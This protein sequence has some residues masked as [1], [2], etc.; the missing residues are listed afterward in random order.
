LI[1]EKGSF[2]QVNNKL[3]LP[4]SSSFSI[5]IPPTSTALSSFLNIK[6]TIDLDN[7]K[8]DPFDRLL[9]RRD[10]ILIQKDANS[11]I[12]TVLNQLNAQ[13][14]GGDTIIH[15]NNLYLLLSNRR[16]QTYA[17]YIRDYD[18]V[19]IGKTGLEVLL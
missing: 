6:K 3:N 2:Q 16:L 10:N 9:K 1:L 8:E 18:Y 11:V 14:W 12:Y 19:F 5:F 4:S 13:R 7:N 15:T 17:E